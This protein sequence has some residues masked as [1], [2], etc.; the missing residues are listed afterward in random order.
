ML[1][2]SLPSSVFHVY[3]ISLLCYSSDNEWVLLFGVCTRTVYYYPFY[4]L[5]TFTAIKCFHKLRIRQ[6]TFVIHIYW[7]YFIEHYHTLLHYSTDTLSSS[8]PNTWV[9]SIFKNRWQKISALFLFYV[10]PLLF[11]HYCYGLF[12]YLFILW[13]LC[14][15]TIQAQYIV[16][17]I[18]EYKL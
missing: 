4:Q 13:V 7:F 11:S 12:I 9:V 6:P 17:N 16:L 10:K 18:I 8:L 2:Y 15:F 14:L 1:I 5:S 3:S